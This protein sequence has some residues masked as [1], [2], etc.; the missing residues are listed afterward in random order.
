MKSILDLS[1]GLHLNV[2]EDVYHQRH[3]G[4][5]SKGALDRIARRSPMHYKA[6]VEGVANDESTEALDF[7]KAL[8]CALLEPDR[9][10]GSHVVMPSFNEYRDAR[11]ALSTKD[12]K[13]AKK[14][15]EEENAGKTHLEPAT[16]DTIAA[17]VRSVHSHPLA[18]KMIRDGAPEVTLRW[19]DDETGLQ[20]KTRADYYVA[21]RKMVVDIKTAHDASYDAFRKAITNYRYHV[22]DALYR[23][24]FGAIG[25]PIEHYVFVVVE[26]TAPYA[27]ATYTLDSESIQK[28]HVLCRDGISDL[29]RCVRDNEWPGY[30]VTIRQINLPPWAA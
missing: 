28:G 30:P 8:H 5:V 13:A 22:T 2:P 25:L 26:K 12:G 29:A 17:M 1:Q 21:A 18:S 16:R 11:G 3:L 23:A 19:R 10:A 6:W 24:S 9:F 27:V 4:L 14:A 7:G 20:C 15:W